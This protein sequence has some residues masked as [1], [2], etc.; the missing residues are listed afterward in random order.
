MFCF[1]FLLLAL[2]FLLSFFVV[3]VFCELLGLKKPAFWRL[4]TQ[5]TANFVFKLNRL[6]IYNIIAFIRV[7]L[8]SLS[9]WLFLKCF[10][11][12]IGFVDWWQ[13]IFE[14]IPLMNSYYI[15]IVAEANN[16]YSL[17]SSDFVL[18]FYIQIGLL[19]C[20]ILFIKPFKLM[21][22]P[23]IIIFIYLII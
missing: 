9:G 21:V 14:G 4:F 17:S 3:T 8:W 18:F 6:D 5:M 22:P 10:E 13:C 7:Q 20:W 15:C 16:I 23:H 11:V 1:V 19:R 2:S 12:R